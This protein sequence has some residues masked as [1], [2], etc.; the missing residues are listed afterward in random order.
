MFTPTKR[1]AGQGAD[2]IA[3]QFQIL[4]VLYE[5]RYES[6]GTCDEERGLTLGQIAKAIGCARSPHL[7]SLMET[8]YLGGSVLMRSYP[9]RPNVNKHIWLISDNARWQ[10]PYLELFD[11]YLGETYGKTLKTPENA[12]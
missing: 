6:D 10:A 4:T 7:R 12:L 5:K 8:M 2:R 1:Q 3:R 11:A 9:Y